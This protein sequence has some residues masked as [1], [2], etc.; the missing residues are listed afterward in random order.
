MIPTSIDGTD[1]TGA[2]I[3]GT[4]VQEI[5]VD[6]QTVFTAGPPVIDDFESGGISAYSGD[7]SDYSVTSSNPI[8]GSNTLVGTTQNKYIFSQSGLANYPS[9]G[10]KFSFKV[11]IDG[12]IN[13]EAKIVFGVQSD[14]TKNY[15][16]GLS[17]FSGLERVLF[18][19]DYSS[20]GFGSD[21]QTFSVPAYTN[22]IF[23][24]E[25]DWSAGGTFL[26]D[27]F[28]ESTS[29]LHGSGSFSD[30]EYSSGGIGWHTRIITSSEATPSR[31]AYDDALIIE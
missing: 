23:R 6:G 12:N 24:F 30:T 2:T 5:T 21:G 16:I 10:D 3:D 19:K 18:R 4:D 25:I 13:I 9:A 31:T 20:G 17:S 11:K 1:I 8:G 7:T 27:V 22:D 29:S 28:N 15:G 14:Q 26:V